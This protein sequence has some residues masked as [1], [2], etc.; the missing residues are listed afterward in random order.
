MSIQKCPNEILEMILEQSDYSISLANSCKRMKF[1]YDN[2]TI[3]IYSELLKLKEELNLEKKY[4]KAYDF[5]DLGQIDVIDTGPETFRRFSAEKLETYFILPHYNEI[6]VVERLFFD[7]NLMDIEYIGIEIGGAIM[8]KLDETLISTIEFKKCVHGNEIFTEVLPIH[9]PHYHDVKVTFRTKTN[10]PIKLYALYSRNK[11][12]LQKFR[13]TD[14]IYVELYC[15][16][17]LSVGTTRNMGHRTVGILII[18]NINDIKNY[19]LRIHP[20]IW[21]TGEHLKEVD[22]MLSVFINKSAL[23][24]HVFPY[25]FTKSRHVF[26]PFLYNDYLYRYDENFFVDFIP[27]NSNL[28]NSTPNFKVYYVEQGYIEYVSGLG[29]RCLLDN[30]TTNFKEDVYV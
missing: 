10:L 25:K 12:L 21:K 11:L 9:L 18:G 17:T 7:G 30:D 13:Y 16:R 29:N 4:K 20:L 24:K 3:P 19:I 23:W 15:L 26:I 6:K 27:K 14:P 8:A 2:L 5:I 1:L 28:K 22:I